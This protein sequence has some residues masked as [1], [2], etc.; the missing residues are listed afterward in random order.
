MKWDYK[1]IKKTKFKI[2]SRKPERK[3]EN[4]KRGTHNFERVKDCTYIGTLLTNKNQLL[5]EI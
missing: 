5:P 3:N 2:A 1:S 4:V